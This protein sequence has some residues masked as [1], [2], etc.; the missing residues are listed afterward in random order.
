MCTKSRTRVNGNYLN[1]AE[2]NRQIESKRQMSHTVHSSVKPSKRLNLLFQ[3]G[4]SSV[5]QLN[6]CQSQHANNQSAYCNVGAIQRYLQATEMSIQT[7]RNE[8]EKC[9][10]SRLTFCVR[11][12]LFTAT[13]P[14][15]PSPNPPQKIY[16]ILTHRFFFSFS[17]FSDILI[18]YADTHMH[19]ICMFNIKFCHWF[20]D[21]RLSVITKHTH[22]SIDRIDS[23][24]QFI[25]WKSFICGSYITFDIE[26]IKRQQPHTVS[27]TWKKKSKM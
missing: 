1:G 14:P 15:S 18:L 6:A 17:I 12:A 24:Q 9:I 5:F 13:P 7:K 11:F 19:D 16:T 23:F 10:V 3:F 4:T 27:L 25:A 26:S 20:F 2:R 8:W 22:T 21:R